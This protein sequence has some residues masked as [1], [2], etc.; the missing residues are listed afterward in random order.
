MT[1]LGYVE[2]KNV[3]YIYHDALGTDPQ[4]NEAEVKSLMGQ[5]VDLLLTLGT[6]ASLAARK[7]VEGTA[8]LWSL[9]QL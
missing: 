2:G 4:K 1:E 6:C 8:L 7:V 9:P 5:K 3:T